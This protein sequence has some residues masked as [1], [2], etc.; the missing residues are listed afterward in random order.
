MFS[1]ETSGAGAEVLLGGLLGGRL[2]RGLLGRRLGGG[3]GGRG[4]LRGGLLGGLRHVRSL[5]ERLRGRSD[6]L[7]DLQSSYNRFYTI[8]Q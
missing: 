7:S 1:R 6:T 3:H 2:L 4:L 5:L 8:F